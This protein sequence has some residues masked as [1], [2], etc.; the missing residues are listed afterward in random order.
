EALARLGYTPGSEVDKAVY[1]IAQRKWDE[2]VKVG[3]AAVEP[4]VGCLRDEDS[5]VREAAA[6]ALG[7]IGDKRAIAALAAALADWWAGRAVAEALAAL[8]WSPTTDAERV[9]WWVARRNGSTLLSHW[10]QAK[11]VLLEDARSGQQIRVEC[12]VYAFV[13]LGREEVVP[14]LIAILD[15]HGDK[16]I[17]EVYLNCG[18][19]RLKKAA[20]EWAHRHGYHVVPG[21]GDAV[22]PG[23]G[24]WR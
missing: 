2:A 21:L 10:P 20:E 8:G 19:A 6:E 11:G 1:L 9:H 16:S 22:G 15:S 14:A 18:H 4:L 17:A 5:D 24:A 13:A 23:W 7:K 12:A 3:G